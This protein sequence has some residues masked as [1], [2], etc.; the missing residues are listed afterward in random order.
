MA[1]TFAFGCKSGYDSEK[2]QSDK[3]SFHCVPMTDK[4]LLTKW[5][6]TRKSN[7]RLDTVSI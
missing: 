7:E 4:E 5:M 2:P 6:D 1:Q 3:V